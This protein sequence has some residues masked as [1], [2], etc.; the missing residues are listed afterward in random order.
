MDTKEFD[1]FVKRQQE[2]AAGVASV[3]WDGTQ[4]MA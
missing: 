4:R 2:A 3:D 1:E